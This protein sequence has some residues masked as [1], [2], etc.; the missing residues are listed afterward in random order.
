MVWQ[1]IAESGGFSGINFVP[2]DERD[3]STSD[4]LQEI[5]FTLKDVTGTSCLSN[6][7]NAIAYC[8]S[9]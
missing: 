9:I 5:Y 1:T 3:Y 4:V 6:S 7:A 8:W 2:Y